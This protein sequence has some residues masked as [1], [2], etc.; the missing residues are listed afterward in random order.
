MGIGLSTIAVIVII[1]LAVMFRR[2]HWPAVSV[3]RVKNADRDPR[4]ESSA[5]AA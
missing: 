1:V 5:V 2:R 3:S 4:R